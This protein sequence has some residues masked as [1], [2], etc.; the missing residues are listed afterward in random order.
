[1]KCFLVHAAI[2]LT[3]KKTSVLQFFQ[4]VRV[5]LK[6]ILC[7]LLWFWFDSRK[8]YKIL[9]QM[10]WWFL[11]NHFRTNGHQIR[12]YSLYWDFSQSH[13]YLRLED[14]LLNLF[15]SIFFINRYQHQLLDFHYRITIW[16]LFIFGFN[17]YIFKWISQ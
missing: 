5:F 10:L 6:K 17:Y 2:K 16:E 1:M 15:T 11:G 4:V 3:N 13:F 7:F 9:M 8:G 12:P 14:K